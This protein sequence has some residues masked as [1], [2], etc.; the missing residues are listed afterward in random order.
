VI[1]V[2]AGAAIPAHGATR[3][4]CNTTR[5]HY[6]SDASA[7]SGLREIPW[8]VAGPFH[9]H[10]FFYGVTPWQREHLAGAHIFTIVKKRNVSPKVLWTHERPGAVPTLLITGRRLDAPGRFTFHA[11]AAND[12]QFPSY[13][14]VPH[15]GCW[16]VTLESGALKG[17]AT[18]AAVDSF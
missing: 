10:L 18:F 14:E 12:S 15:A 8:I 9:G 3:A 7:A 6:A 5:V 11:E 1:A 16:R 13:V 4:A 17:S 2:V